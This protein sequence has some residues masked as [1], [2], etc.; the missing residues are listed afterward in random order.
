[1]KS[2]EI[3][4]VEPDANGNFRREVFEVSD[5]EVDAL[6]LEIRRVAEEITELSFWN[7]ACD[8]EQCNYCDLVEVLQKKA[9]KPTKSLEKQVE[10]ATIYCT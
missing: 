8:P 5:E 7:T 4:F 6:E 9:Q 3:M 2:G 1:M 10:Y